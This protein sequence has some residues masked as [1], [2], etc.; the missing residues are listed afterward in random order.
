MTEIPPVP[1]RSVLSHSPPRPVLL[2]VCFVRMKSGARNVACVSTDRYLPPSGNVYWQGI[3]AHERTFAVNYFAHVEMTYLLL[4]S[5]VDG[6][7]RV[8]NGRAL[9]VP[10]LPRG[11]PARSLTGSLFKSL[12]PRPVLQT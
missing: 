6:K 4:P 8:I 3:D 1:F 2:P 5:L 12:S 10:L 9:F 11:A 7:G